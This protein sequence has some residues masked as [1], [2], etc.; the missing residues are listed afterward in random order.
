MGKRGG[1]LLTAGALALLTAC[2]APAPVAPPT[3]TAT[4]TSTRPA[5]DRP[6]SE[7]PALGP[8]PGSRPPTTPQPP[9]PHSPAKVTSACP[10]L[11]V[12]ESSAAMGV[13]LDTYAVEE[14][15]SSQQGATT[16]HC[17]YASRTG[18]R[19]LFD[20]YITVVPGTGQVPALVR[21]WTKPCVEPATPIAGV[22]GTTRTCKLNDNEAGNGRGYGD[23]MLLVVKKS[24]GQ[25]RL[26][27]LDMRP[28][29]PEVYT[30]LA[31][32]LSDR[33]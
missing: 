31:G 4:A 11:G 14:A 9:P 24:H 13:V 7:A 15:P 8:G 17:N 32:L 6:S 30:K 19:Q 5:T 29:A 22:D 20:L 21:E 10:F 2:S 27:E 12:T 28:F 26:A 1:I 3:T 25:T 18:G 33:L 23:V 16:Y